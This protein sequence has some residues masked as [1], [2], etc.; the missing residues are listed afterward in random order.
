M[1]ENPG[2]LPGGARGIRLAF[3]R[4]AETGEV[5]QVG[6]EAQAEPWR[7]EGVRGVASSCEAGWGAPSARIWLSQ[8]VA[9]SKGTLARGDVSRPAGLITTSLSVL[10]VGPCEVRGTFWASA[11]HGPVRSFVHSDLLGSCRNLSSDK[12]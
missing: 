5:K 9:G 11:H 1:G 10:S 6:E 12:N 4:V 3:S 2:R 7:R 8:L